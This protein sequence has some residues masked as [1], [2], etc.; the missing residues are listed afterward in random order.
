MIIEF[1]N[2]IRHITRCV[3]LSA[4]HRV[5]LPVVINYHGEDT[6]PATWP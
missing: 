1:E 4:Y 6:T 3:Y 5:V 2:I